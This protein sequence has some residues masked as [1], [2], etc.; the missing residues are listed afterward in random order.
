LQPL[1]ESDIEFLRHARVD[2]EQRAEEEFRLLRLAELE[3]MRVEREQE[4]AR[5]QIEREAEQVWTVSF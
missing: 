4:E 2:A 1:S 3:R 5:L